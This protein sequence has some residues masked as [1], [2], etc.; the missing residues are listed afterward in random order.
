M[1]QIVRRVEDERGENQQEHADAE[2]VLHR[3]VG[4]EIHR[5][6]RAL[7]ID[8]QRVV[9]LD[10]VQGPDVQDDDPENDEG[11]QIMQAVEAVER[12]VVDRET[13]PQK[14][15]QGF[16]DQRHGADH[17]GNHLGGPEAHLAP[18][19]HIAHEGRGHHEEQDDHAQPPEQFARR[20]E[21]A[22]VE[23][24]EYVQIHHNEEH[25]PAV[26]VN[27]ADQPAVVDVAHDAL[28]RIEGVVRV[29]R[30]VH[31][32]H[33]AGHDHDDERQ[34]GERAENSTD[35]SDCAAPDNRACARS[36]RRSACDR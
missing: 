11:Q 24:A 17:A 33:D 20:L 34:A 26:H 36:W 3:V 9:R 19:Q 15:G 8:A 5:I 12:R 13:A 30:V 31:R 35:S 27:V 22:V 1:A 4:M 25:R 28:D 16:A 23:A 21:G 2:Q 14:L 32:Q 10:R 7:H 6:L 18:G 29:G